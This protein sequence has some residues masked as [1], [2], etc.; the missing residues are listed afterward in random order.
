MSMWKADAASGVK[1][2]PAR[3]KTLLQRP[4]KLKLHWEPPTL[5][6]DRLVAKTRE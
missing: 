4:D 6:D 2:G 3:G 1:H 5:L